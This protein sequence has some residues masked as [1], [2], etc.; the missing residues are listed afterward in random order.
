MTFKTGL[1]PAAIAEVDNEKNAAFALQQSTTVQPTTVQQ[2]A[3]LHS[4]FIREN[5]DYDP[6]RSEIMQAARLAS[7]GYITF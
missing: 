5:L 4:A 6:P 2:L 1:V 3:F 7:C